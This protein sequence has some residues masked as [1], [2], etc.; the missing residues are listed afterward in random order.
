MFTFNLTSPTEVIRGLSERM[1]RRRIDAGLTQ[2]ELA[3]RA[4]VSYG[5]LR[6]F[7]ETGKISLEAIVKIAFVLEAEAEFEHLFPPRPPKTIDDVVG[8]PVRKRVR[9]K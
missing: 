7:E 6:L 2:R 9:K 1:K 4:G 5:S 8:R 3:V